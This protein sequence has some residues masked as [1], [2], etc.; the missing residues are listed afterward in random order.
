MVTSYKVFQS[1]QK[2][3]RKTTDYMN[4]STLDHIWEMLQYAICCA[5]TVINV[6]SASKMFVFHLDGSLPPLSSMSH[7][8]CVS[9][10]FTSRWLPTPAH[11]RH[12]TVWVLRSDRSY[13]IFLMAYCQCWFF[14]H[15]LQCRERNMTRRFFSGNNKEVPWSVSFCG[16]NSR[17]SG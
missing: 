13:C 14:T 10:P 3:L 15:R 1:K 5:R 2:W 8:P 4:N 7:T 9:E 16:F 12:T 6:T 17:C 11:K